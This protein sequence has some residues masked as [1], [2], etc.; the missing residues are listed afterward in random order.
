MVQSLTTGLHVKG[1]DASHTLGCANILGDGGHRFKKL[2][3]LR[4]MNTCVVYSDT[5]SSLQIQIIID[6]F[7]NTM[8]F[9]CDDLPP[10][11]MHLPS[12]PH[13]QPN[14]NSVGS[15]ELRE[16]TQRSLRRYQ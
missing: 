5:I 13:D 2:C 16:T 14:P 7:L 6:S 15:S 3:E 11:T 1:I 8:R 12:T 4:I 10:D 9:E